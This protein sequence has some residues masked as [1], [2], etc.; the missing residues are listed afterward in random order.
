MSIVNGFLKTVKLFMT[1]SQQIVNAVYLL[2]EY[3]NKK[4]GY[5]FKGGLR[6]L[7]IIKPCSGSKGCGIEIVDRLEKINQTFG[8]ASNKMVQKYIEDIWTLKPA[9]MEEFKLEEDYNKILNKKFDIRQWVLI[10]PPY[11]YIFSSFYIR[12]C[13]K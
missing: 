11:S 9:E 13:S 10:K 6:N 2:H 4:A 5:N 12:I 1:P 3:F 8:T 7:W